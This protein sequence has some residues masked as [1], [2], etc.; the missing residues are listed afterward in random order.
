MAHSYIDHIRIDQNTYYIGGWA[1]SDKNE[2]ATGFVFGKKKKHALNFT[3]IER[4]DLVKKSGT[5]ALMAGFEVALTDAEAKSF[6][7]DSNADVSANFSDDTSLALTAPRN[8]KDYIPSKSQ[9]LFDKS[10]TAFIELDFQRLAA[11]LVLAQEVGITLQLDSPILIEKAIAAIQFARVD[12]K[13]AKPLLDRLRLQ[14]QQHSQDPAYSVPALRLALLDAAGNHPLSEL[15]A[16]STPTSSQDVYP[17]FCH[18]VR[19]LHDFHLSDESAE[20]LK[21]YMAYSWTNYKLLADMLGEMS[22]DELECYD[23]LCFVAQLLY[24]MS[25]LKAGEEAVRIKEHEVIGVY[26]KLFISGL[27]CIHPNQLAWL[28]TKASLSQSK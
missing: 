28:Q 2:P 16:L 17:V 20:S 27:G 26:R 23:R 4:K 7:I 9:G 25:W 21:D 5:S 8:I 22:L 14:I 13:V 15:A 11:Y 12:T 1:L 19:L 6:L 18:S 3:A 24:R 10:I